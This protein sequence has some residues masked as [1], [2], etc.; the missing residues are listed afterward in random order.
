MGSHT[1]KFQSWLYR[2]R[3]EETEIEVEITYTVYPGSQP[4]LYGDYPYPGDDGEVEV[5]SV[6]ANGAEFATTREEDNRLYDLCCARAD[7]DLTDWHAEAAE[8]RADMRR[9]ERDLW[10]WAEAAE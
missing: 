4:Q 9:D 3:N 1:F 5:I 2:G 10:D 8:Y 6:K 7:E